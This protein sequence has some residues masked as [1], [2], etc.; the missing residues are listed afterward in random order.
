L[1]ETAAPAAPELL[2]EEAKA[3]GRKAAVRGKTKPV[4]AAISATEISP[5][6]A[7]PVAAPAAEAKAD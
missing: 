3:D 6:A 7:A 1:E 5:P 4:D 2:A